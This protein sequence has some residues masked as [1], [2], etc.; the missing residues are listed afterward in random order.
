MQDIV[1]I[2]RSAFTAPHVALAIGNNQDTPRTQ[3]NT[4]MIVQ[5]DWASSPQSLACIQ[6]H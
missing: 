5:C 3:H 2:A 1:G 4:W 6:N